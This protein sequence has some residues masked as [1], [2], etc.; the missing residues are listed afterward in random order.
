MLLAMAGSMGIDDAGFI[1]ALID[2][3]AASYPQ[4]TTRIYATRIYAM[5][6]H[7]TGMSNGK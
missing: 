6:V 4:D 7:A 2:T 5:R 3:N 1:S